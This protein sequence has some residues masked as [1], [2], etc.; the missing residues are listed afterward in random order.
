M[1]KL[2]ITGSNDA[3]VIDG[4]MTGAVVKNTLSTASDAL[5]VADSLACGKLT[6]GDADAG[7]NSFKTVIYKGAYG[8]VLLCS[9]GSWY[10]LNPFDSRLDTLNEGQRAIDAVTIKGGGR[11]HPRDQRYRERPERMPD[12]GEPFT[13]RGDANDFDVYKTGAV[14][15]SS[16][17]SSALANANITYGTTGGDTFDGKGATTCWSAL[18]ARTSPRAARGRTP[19]ASPTCAT[20]ATRSPTSSTAPTRS[21][22]RT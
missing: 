19:S 13:G 3:A 16:I 9:D 10:I 6:I 18:S 2:Q 22:C 12:G 15:F 4:T 20:P 5:T 21:N 1:I 11:N 7:Q 17:G 8:Y 14:V